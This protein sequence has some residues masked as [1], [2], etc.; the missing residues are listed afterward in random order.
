M[1]K[2]DCFKLGFI[3][4][5][6]GIKGEVV[7]S[8]MVDENPIYKKMESV[9]VEINQQFVPFFIQGISIHKNLAIVNLEGI[10]SID[11]AK[12]Y[13]KSSV[14]LPLSFLPELDNKNFYFHEVI[15]FEVNDKKY[16]VIGVVESVLEFPG[17][18]IFQIRHQNK[19]ELLIPARNEFIVN[20]D[21]KNKCLSIDAPDGLIDVYLKKDTTETDEEE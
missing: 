7:I 8:L 18:K 13:V 10:T 9:F 17:Q 1:E 21:R 16:G 2:Q 19:I 15:G 4:K 12:E 20:V 3:S 14:Y 5:T 11:Q 6:H